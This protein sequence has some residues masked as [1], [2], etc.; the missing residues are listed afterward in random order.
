MDLLPQ[1]GSIFQ[2]LVAFVVALSIIVAIHEYGHYIIGRLSGIKAEVFSLG[3]GPVLYSRVDRHGTRWQLAALPFGGYVKF[4]GDSDAASGR[5]AEAMT[6]LDESDRRKTMHGAPLWARTATVAAGPVFNFIL[7]IIVFAGLFMVRGDVADPLTVDEMRPLPPSYAMLEPGDQVLEIGGVPFPGAEDEAFA[8]FDEAVP[9]ERTLDYRVIRGG[10]TR[11]VAGPYPYPPLIT[12]LAP[13]S[14]AYDIGM[15][16]GD[17]I[18]A[19]DGDDIFAFAQLKDRVEGSEGAALALKVWRE[20]AGEPLDFALAPRRVDEPDPEG[21]FRTEWRIGIAGGMAFEPATEG[22]GPLTA[23]G[24]GV[25]Q[26]WRI[27]ESSI[28]G[29]W[30]MITG[31]ISTCNMTGPIGIAQTSGAM[32]SQGAVSFIWFVAAL[33]TAVGLLNLFPIPVL[34]GGHL[35]FFGYEAVAGKPPSDFAL[36]MLMGAG[37]MLILS[38]MVFALTNDV[39]CP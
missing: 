28:S 6:D 14:A 25:Q 12:Q 35:V 1:F 19:V 9:L 11:T 31:A 13:N 29:L 16:P 38:V 4:L 24:N 2:T 21:G 20:G 5:S 23:V 22:V 36:R 30:H 39:L 33:S 32:A 37:L 7:S 15:K 3:F 34:D 26:T 10:E 18:L 8:D 17:V 27:A